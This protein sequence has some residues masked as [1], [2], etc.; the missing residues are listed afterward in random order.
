MKTMSKRYQAQLKTLAIAQLLIPF[1]VI[2]TGCTGFDPPA[3]VPGLETSTPPSTSTLELPSPVSPTVTV[4]ASTKA[5]VCTNTP[6]GKLHVRFAPGKDSAV[7]G[8]LTEKESVTLS[9]EQREMDGELWVKLSRPIEGWIN[10]NYLCE[11]NN[12]DTQIIEIR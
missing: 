1:V 2:L 9:G 12:N 10:A 3:Y 11:V 4:P 8:Y 7:R 6:N 5:V